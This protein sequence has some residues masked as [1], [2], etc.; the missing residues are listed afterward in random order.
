M[1]IVLLGAPGSGKGTQS[2]RL[3]E[4]F[5]IPQISTG[6]L[7]RSAVARGTPLGLAAKDAMQAGKLVDD[8]IVL[9]MIR[10]RL[11]DADTANGFILDG[12]PRNIA[13]AQALDEMLVAE[14]KPLTTVV[15]MEVPYGQLTRRIAGRR[16]CRSCGSV[17]NI[18]S[19]ELDDPPR[20]RSC[21]DAPLLY[22]RPDDNEETVAQRLK[23]YESQTRPLLGY[24]RRRKLLQS[25][26]AQ[27]DIDAITQL[28]VRAIARPAVGGVRVKAAPTKKKVKKTVARKAKPAPRRTEPVAKKTKVAAKKKAAKKAVAKKK[29]VAKKVVAKKKVAAKKK[30]VAKKKVAARKK[31]VAKKKVVARKK[32][33]A[34]KA[35]VARKKATRGKKVAAKKKAA[36]KTARR[37][38]RKTVARAKSTA[39]ARVKARAPRRPAARK[40]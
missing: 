8:A 3:V 38:A 18:Y 40:K 25:I 32:V 17:Y 23:V 29:V 28:L 7:L 33:A 30:V 26:D 10:E 20:C 35:V 4:R 9:G 27:G 24:Y 12:F 1:R 19:M 39:S 6:D 22:Q 36:R 15:Q 2:Q 21:Q 11:A 31:V 14:G 34:K 13:Q 37:Y 16:S 5:G